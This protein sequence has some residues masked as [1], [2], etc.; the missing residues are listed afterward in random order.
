MREKDQARPGPA[1]WLA[2]RRPGN[3]GERIYAHLPWFF[4][5]MLV[6]LL[7]LLPLTRLPVGEC[8]FL[9]ITGHPCPFC[10]ITRS[11]CD[12]AQGH[13]A[14]AVVNGPLYAAGYLAAVVVALFHG[15]AL[16][17]R[18]VIRLGTY[19]QPSAGTKSMF[20]TVLIIL[21]FANWFYR[22][23]VGFDAR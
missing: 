1:R 3:V 20:W 2:V 16:A 15:T 14:D 18:R 10:G 23:A 9:C 5:S 4:L 12:M 13:W 11:L 17:S 19:F 6:V 7:P 8:L 22:L 21:L